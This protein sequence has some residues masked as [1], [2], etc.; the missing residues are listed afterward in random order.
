MARASAGRSSC[1]KREGPLLD[2]VSCNGG[3]LPLWRK[4]VY[5][6][7]MNFKPGRRPSRVDVTASQSWD[8][9]GGALSHGNASRSFCAVHFA[10]ESAGD[11]APEPDT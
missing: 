1:P 2:V 4:G 5:D 7:E 6:I 11:R 8:S 3:I 10:V 9:V